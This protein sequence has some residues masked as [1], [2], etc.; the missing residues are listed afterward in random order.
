VS[1]AGAGITRQA[2][3]EKFT[4]RDP[5][6]RM[7][8]SKEELHRI[9]SLAIPPAWTA[10]W[11]CPDAAGHIQATGRDARGRKQ[12]RYHPDWTARREA[13]K[14]VRLLQLAETLPAIRR[15]VRR[16][17]T[18]PGLPREKVLALM[19]KL[20][21]ITA[22]RPGHREYAQ[23]NGSYGL[24]SMKDSHA[25]IRSGSV[26][27]RFN[28]K[29]GKR[30]SLAVEDKRIAKLVEQCRRLSGSALFQYV[31][32][33]RQPR[34]VHAGDLN[35]YL[36]E[37]SKTTCH[38]QRSANVECH[39]GRMEPAVEAARIGNRQAA[40]GRSSRRCL[41]RG[42]A[43]GQHPHDLPHFI[44]SPSLAGD[45]SCGP[46]P[47]LTIS[48]IRGL[49]RPESAVVCLLRQSSNQVQFALKRSLKSARQPGRSH[50]A[51]A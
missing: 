18:K 14:T 23:Q 24:A 16:D 28:G 7:V 6:G 25:C 12:Y 17:L 38:V 46:P 1:D 8:K 4:Y 13:Q 10:V 19:V 33:Q 43:V 39:R 3:G 45:I 20:L 35:R 42:G 9:K 44:H 27:F 41:R 29:G 49:S 26:A 50:R 2:R 5:A 36:N 34:P 30:Q 31:N 15:R 22:I 40:E 37:I 47:S 32:E 48:R 21:E 51:A 11:I